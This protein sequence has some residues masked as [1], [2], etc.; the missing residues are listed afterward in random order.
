MVKNILIA[1]VAIFLIALL[2]IW[3]ISGGPSKVLNQVQNGPGI[4][5]TFLGTGSSTGAFSFVL[6]FQPTTTYT[7]INLGYGNYEEDGV[8]DDS[9]TAEEEYEIE[10]QKIKEAQTF[11]DPSPYRGKIYFGT[12]L[13]E[14]H[15]NIGEEY[16]EIH[17]SDE[18]T[19][20]VSITGWSLQS[21]VSG[22]RFP[23]SAGV[24]SLTMGTIQPSENIMFGA[25]MRA[26]ISTGSSPFG[27]SF[28]EN[29][30]T[31]YLSQFSAFSPSLESSCPSAA[32]ELPR[33][34]QNISA[35]GVSCF[36][37]LESIPSCTTP[38]SIS[39]EASSACANFIRQTLTY[40]GCADRH[41]WRSTFLGNTW[42]IYLGSNQNTWGDIHD[43]VRLLDADGRVVDVL[44][45]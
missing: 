23:I 25:G 14:A 38:T 11:G 12:Y 33:T 39:T 3:L 37:V 31:G 18:L 10:Q 17:G 6:P 40:N 13:T 26:I 5:E 32:S 16:I 2:A 24:Q 4:F 34:A 44:S 15:T 30:C 28:R 22:K 9:L 41:R 7:G 36:G 27:A 29:M 21:M 35:Y 8:T 20:P 45:Y 42:R 43:V 1:F 19:T